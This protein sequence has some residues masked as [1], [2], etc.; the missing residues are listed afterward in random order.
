[1]NLSRRTFLSLPLLLAARPVPAQQPAPGNELWMIQPQLPTPPLRY[2][3]AYPGIEYAVPL[4]ARVVLPVTYTV[5]SPSNARV[6]AKGML[7]FVAPDSGSVTVDLTMTDARGYTKDLSWTVTVDPNPFIFVD[8]NASAG[9]DGTKANPFRS[10][11]D[12]WV[13]HPGSSYPYKNKF[14]YVRAGTYSLPARGSRLL[15]NQ[16]S[17]VIGYP[18]E[19][20]LFDCGPDARH[21][22][23]WKDDAFFHNLEY[24]NG[25]NRIYWYENSDNLV[26]SENI[27]H[28]LGASP[29][30]NIGF[31]QIMNDTLW[32]GAPVSSP[33]PLDASGVTYRKKNALLHGCDIT[34]DNKGVEMYGTYNLGIMFNRIALVSD[35]VYA[36]VNGKSSNW[37]TTVVGNEFYAPANNSIEANKPYTLNIPGQFYALDWFIAN[38]LMVGGVFMLGAYTALDHTEVLWNT[39]ECNIVVRKTKIGDGPIIFDRNVIVNDTGD[40]IVDSPN[41]HWSP[42]AQVTVIKDN[43]MGST[44]DGILDSNHKITNPDLKGKYGYEKRTAPRPPARLSIT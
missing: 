15:P 22:G 41:E 37:I 13:D 11:S 20:V 30:D 43:L 28:D 23:I 1:M 25:V 31:L 21:W 26:I 33:P 39:L 9:G 19:T 2:R 14:V 10:F 16:I 36:C 42:E 5:R 27:C 4:A 3:Y 34:S 6:D 8:G 35:K 24:T 38:N 32:N 12:F 40:H 18:G 17:G 7:R 29:Q 44:A